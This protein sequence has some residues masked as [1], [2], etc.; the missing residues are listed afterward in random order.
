MK[1][2]RQRRGSTRQ[3]PVGRIAGAM[4]AI[5]GLSRI[6]RRPGAAGAA[7]AT[8]VSTTRTRSSARSWSAARPST[9]Q[10]EQDSLLGEVPEGLAEPGAQGMNKA[11]AGTA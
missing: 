3:I 9:P 8:V 6:C 7:T 11:K 2:S 1:Q 5:G 4:L 10:G